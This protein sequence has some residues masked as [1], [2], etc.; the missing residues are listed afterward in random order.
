MKKM[1]E[2]HL[3]TQIIDSQYSTGKSGILRFTLFSYYN[4]IWISSVITTGIVFGLVHWPFAGAITSVGLGLLL[5]FSLN[6]LIEN[7]A[8]IILDSLMLVIS[9]SLSVYFQLLF[10]RIRLLIYLILAIALILIL[11]K[12]IL[13]KRKK[14]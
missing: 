10:W 8:R 5:A 6:R 12:V 7:R 14:M 13:K 9:L 2:S 1:I 3:E 4:L 11:N